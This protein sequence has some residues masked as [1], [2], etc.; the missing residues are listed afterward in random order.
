MQYEAASEQVPFWQRCEQHSV[1]AAH[2]LP[3][4]LHAALSGRHTPA[5]QVPLQQV[6]DEVQAALSATQVDRLDAQK[7][8]TQERLQQSVEYW[9]G[10][11]GSEH[12]AT[13]ELQVPELV[14]QIP[15]QQ[16]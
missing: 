6:A 3:A 8:P 15:E 16:T 13:D 2:G 9:H 14:S 4:V 5:A 1:L 11:P 7:P 10:S 12:R